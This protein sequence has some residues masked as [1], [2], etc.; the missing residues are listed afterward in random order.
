[1]KVID[2]KDISKAGYMML[3]YGETGSGKTVSSLQTAPMPILYIQTEPRSLKPSIE[4]A[5]RKDLDLKVAE[6]TDFNELME[7][8]ANPANTEPYNTIVLDSL[9]H[10][11]NISLSSE[12]TD[13]AFESRA[14]KDK[15]LKQLTAK[16]K[17]SQEAYG[18]LAANLFRMV[19]LLG[20]ISRRGKVVISL[21]LLS[22]NPKW[23]RELA[24]AP[25]LKG[26]EFPNSMPGFFD[27]IGRLQTRV[28]ENDN[29]VYP[30]YVYF[31][32]ADDSFMAKFTGAG[33]KTEGVYNVGRIVGEAPKGKPKS[34][35]K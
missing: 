27:L 17:M 2:Y 25:T 13:E 11:S 31:K 16:T 9:T 30:P 35:S 20:N 10:L 22:E 18:A 14:D 15:I 4:A 23:N 33:N 1:M 8:I 32:S 26:R 5:N 19:S 29:I 21:C 7:F 3:I 12:L 24:A 34:E 28:D 6:Y